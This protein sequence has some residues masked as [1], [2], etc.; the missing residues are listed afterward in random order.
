MTRTATYRHTPAKTRRLASRVLALGT[1]LA[2]A[3]STGTASAQG[4]VFLPRSLIPVIREFDTPGVTPHVIAAGPNGDA[5]FTAVGD[6]P[7]PRLLVGQIT[8][9]GVQS[10]VADG[11][12]QPSPPGAQSPPGVPDEGGLGNIALGPDGNLWFIQGAQPIPGTDGALAPTCQG[13]VYRMTPNGDI[14]HIRGGAILPNP[15]WIAAG[16]DGDLWLTEGADAIA[17]ITPHGTVNPPFSSGVLPGNPAGVIAP[18]P[19]GNLW[20]TEP[21]SGRLGNLAPSLSAP[22]GR[23][24]RASCSS[25]H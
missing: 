24:S 20:F 19:D 11:I 22:A 1:L 12:I 9:D 14:S 6:A 4:A 23:S 25:R 18:G 8:P 16:P 2:V 5:Y 17:R 13:I 21:S 10:Y 15:G 3:G 7:N